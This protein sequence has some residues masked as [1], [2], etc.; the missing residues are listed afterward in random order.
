[1]ASKLPLDGDLQSPDDYIR[2]V[3]GTTGLPEILCRKN[4][5]KIQLVLN[6]M[7][8]VLGGLTR[9]LDLSVLDSGWGVQNKRP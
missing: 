5:K 8:A 9:G 2:Q 7:E 3:S 4:M 1:M 6:E